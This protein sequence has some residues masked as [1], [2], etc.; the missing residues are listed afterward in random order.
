MAGSILRRFASS[1]VLFFLVLTLTFMLVRIAPGSPLNMYENPHLTRA[2]MQDLERAYG[3]DKPLPVQ[4]V[5]WLR[6][7]VFEGNWGISFIHQRP[8]IEVIWAALPNTLLL[9]LTAL[10]LQYGLG[11][12][13][14]VAAARRAGGT[15]DSVLRVTSLLIYSVPTF[16]LGLMAILL[17]HLHWHLLPAGGLTSPGI[18]D[19]PALARAGD[20]LQHL[21]LPAGVLGLTA[22]ARVA[23]FVRS[24]LLDAL[25][26]DYVRTA[27]AKGLPERRVLWLHGLRNSLVPL[28][29][30]LGMSLP[31]LLNGTLVVEVVFGWPGLGRLL[32]DAAS[33]RDFPVILAGT[34]FGALLVIF[35]SI[36]ADLLHHAADPR[37]RHG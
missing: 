15:F 32:F 27:R 12:L 20:L 37:L 24:S 34:A 35:G 26:Q 23:R 28:A 11:L 13:M 18:D 36:L 9:G 31:S 19:A 16:W 22:A 8:A 1:A 7:V 3:F 6:A 29:Q 30:L 5:S 4:Y 14:G 17:F 25:S 21:I 2:Q 10:L 33:A